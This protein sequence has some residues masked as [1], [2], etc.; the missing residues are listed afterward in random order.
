[1][2]NNMKKTPH[3]SGKNTG[4]I[5]ATT[6]GATDMVI[7]MLNVRKKRLLLVLQACM[8][9]LHQYEAVRTILLD[10]LGREGFE[11]DLEKVLGQQ[12]ERNGAGGNIQAG[13]GVPQ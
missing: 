12:T 6:S 8:P 2:L 9:Q 4:N 13:K 5:Y 7:E 11:K 10:E 1:M 3:R